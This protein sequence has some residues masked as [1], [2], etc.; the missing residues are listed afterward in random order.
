MFPII[1]IFELLRAEAQIA[2]A[3][4][5]T[6]V[7]VVDG[8]D[9]VEVDVDVDVLVVVDVDVLAVVVVEK[10]PTQPDC[11]RVIIKNHNS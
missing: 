8:V 1:A 3:D 6:T 9:V 11:S 10:L 2:E 5:N 7:V 4:D